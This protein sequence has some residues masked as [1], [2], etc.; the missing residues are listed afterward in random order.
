[1]ATEQVTLSIDADAA[2]VYKT[3]SPEERRKLEAL[4]SLRLLEATR[5]SGS[6]SEIM[7]EISCNAQDRGLTPE[8]L[9]SILDAD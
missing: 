2:R 3:A 6:L 8:I 1:M 5:T 4:V 9:R 7:T